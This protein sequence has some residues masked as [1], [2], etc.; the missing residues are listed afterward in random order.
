MRRHKLVVVNRE[1]REAEGARLGSADLSSSATLCIYKMWGGPPAFAN[2]Q[3]TAATSRR[4]APT[5]WRALT[6]VAVNFGHFSGAFINVFEDGSLTSYR[7]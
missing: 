7:R 4:I 3:D 6:H 1:T 5:P 2:R